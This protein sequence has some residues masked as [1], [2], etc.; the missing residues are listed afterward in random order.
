[1]VVGDVPR[2]R[3]DTLRRRGSGQPAFNLGSNIGCCHR[4]QWLSTMERDEGL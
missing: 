1:M 2:D 3:V 4:N